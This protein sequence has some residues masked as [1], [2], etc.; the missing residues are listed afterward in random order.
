MNAL[1]FCRESVLNID[2]FPIDF[3]HQI[4]G[5]HAV[6]I[7]G[8]WYVAW[9]ST[10]AVNWTWAF[11]YLVL[12][13]ARGLKQPETMERLSAVGA[14]ISASSPEEFGAF[15]KAEREKWARVIKAARIRAE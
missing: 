12:Q 15:M 14:E 10:T 13:A 4:R 11:A 5:A 7:A 3:S 8:L 9:N 6:W 1:A 2:E